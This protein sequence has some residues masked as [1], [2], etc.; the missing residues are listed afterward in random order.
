M[1]RS[2]LRLSLRVRIIAV[3]SVVLAAG[4]VI[5]GLAAWHSA[6]VAAQQAYDRLLTGGTVQ[7]AENVYVQ[8]GVVALEPPASAIATLSAYDLVFYKVVDPRGI[9]VAGYEDLSS[10]VSLAQARTGV[11]IEDGTYQGQSVRIATVARRID[12]PAAGGWAT[13]VV[14]QTVEA[15][16]ALARALTL[17]ALAVIAVMSALALVA[18]GLAVK[19]A[20]NP[21]TR[22]E[23]EIMSRRPDDLRPLEA[24]PPVEIRNLVQAIDD[25]MR[26]L[27]DRMA[28]MQRFIADAAHQIRTPLAALDAQVEILSNAPP[29]RR[30]GAI[31]RIRE[32]ASELAHLTGQLL[33]H[34]MVIHRA[35]SVPTVPI[36]LN[37]LAKSVLA[38]SVPLSLP[39]EVDIAFA[40]AANAPTI[41]GDPVILREALGNLIDNALCHGAR[42]RMIVA[43]GT[44][45]E[46]AWIEVRD[47]GD[48]FAAAPQEFVA[49][50]HKG[51]RSTGSGLGLAI[52]ADVARVHHGSLVFGRDDRMT[53][54]RLVLRLQR[55]TSGMGFD[56]SE[57]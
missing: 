47:D 5:L 44:D 51:E 45:T 25:F 9:V 13:I 39:R 41:E 10:K 21:L 8:G 3:L 43:V 17:K 18:T 34:A 7:I 37:A 16:R 56:R 38:K 22:I 50:F 15:R 36:D 11:V 6:S 55:R 54:V 14:A 48:G 1:R 40:P 32:R 52:A 49:P 31:E 57:T 30:A 26:R 24:E 2:D 23:R 42:S 33:D 20:L 27:S 12:D 53:S 19:V 35:D 29:A 46:H 4:A 28:V